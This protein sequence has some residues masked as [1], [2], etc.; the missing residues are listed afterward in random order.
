MA[1][2]PELIK[3]F[4]VESHENL[5]RLDQDFVQLEKCPSDREMIS[6]I[7]RTIHTIKGTCGFLGFSRLEEITHVGESL[8]VR[9]R[10]GQLQLNGDMATGLLRMVD[11]VREMLSHIEQTATEGEGNYVDLISTLTALS[12]GRVAEAAPAVD[13]VEALLQEEIRKSNARLLEHAAAQTAPVAAKPEVA[14]PAA[15]AS[16]EPAARAAIAVESSI[17]VDVQLLDRLMN[18]VGELVLARN[19]VLAHTAA[20]NNVALSDA[21]Q[22]LSLITA[23][24]QEAVM[25]TRMQ[26]ISNIWSKLP[27]VV[28]DLAATCGKQVEVQMEGQETELDKTIIEAIKDPL[29]HVVRNAVDHG[30]E[31]AE[32]RR[33]AGK[34]ETGTL[35]LRAFHEGGQVNI[36]ISDDG[37]GIRIGRVKQKAIERG[38]IPEAEAARMTDRD[39]LELIF[40]PR[41]STAATVTSVSG[42]GVGMDVVKTNIERIGGA[43]DLQSVE[44]RGSTLRFK[45]PLTLAIIPALVVESGGERFAIPQVNMLELVRL[46]AAE[47]EKIEQLY[48][49]PVYRLRDTLL[50]LVDLSQQLKL[51]KETVRDDATIVVVRVEDMRFGLIVDRVVDSAEIVV[52]P[53]DS[54]LKGLGVYAGATVM[55]DGHVCLILD[56]PGL[57]ARAHVSATEKPAA[58]TSAERT[59][60]GTSM[61]IVQT[62]GGGRFAIPLAMVARL[63][64]WP[65][66]QMERTGGRLVVQYRGGIMPVTDLGALAGAPG[67]ESGASGE[68]LHA[69]VCS[70][71]GRSV[72]L[73]CERILDIVALAG[74]VDGERARPGISGSAVLAGRITEVIDVAAIAGGQPSAS[75]GRD[76]E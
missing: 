9:L 66:A 6:R 11:A 37:G 59:S 49:S 76:A 74:D 14:A 46:G 42:R 10:D 69:V 30:I 67:A 55:G 8:L 4:L 7:F 52:K 73:I 35:S 34:P 1:E 28:R 61:L 50:P 65:R 19:Q 64:E 45:I 15:T 36:E 62:A 47:G 22:R 21:S 68:V 57:A 16:P 54:L 18:L 60:N 2:N 48:G 5:D 38:M 25:K 44:G 72:G 70:H 3:E 33:A 58:L 31:T 23:G 24:L 56:V 17:R 27:R 12:K 51:P 32:Q 20:Q 53:L 43:V 39:A 63:E 40:R 13:P 29:T 71:G 26:P 41:F 75:Y